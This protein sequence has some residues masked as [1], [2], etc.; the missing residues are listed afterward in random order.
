MV[1]TRSDRR[2][3]AKLVQPNNREQ[4]TVIKYINISGWCIPLFI[5]IKGTY[6]LSNQ[7]IESGFPN[8]WVVKP[9]PSKWTNN[10]TGLDWIQYFNR[11][12]KSRSTGVHRMLIINGHESYI[13]VEFNEYYKVNNIITISMPVYSSHILQ[14]LDV[15]L[16]SP[17]KSAYGHQI[18]L[19]I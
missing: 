6:H 11:Y 15:G 7:T 12:T 19:F 18:S 14:L 5:I 10:K 17:L 9:T 3:K 16:Y 2:G 8:D 13:S 4:A 1:V